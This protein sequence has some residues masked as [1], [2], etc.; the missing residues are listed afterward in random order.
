VG[1]RESLPINCENWWEAYAF[2]IWDEGFLPSAAE[3]EYAAAGGS[4]QREYPW[5]SADPGVANQYAIYLCD[6]P[7]IG[8]CTG[9]T[10]IAPVGTPTLGAGRWGQLDLA[11]NVEEWTL[12][13]AG[14]PSMCV[15]CFFVPTGPGP[16][17]PSRVSEGGGYGFAAW[18]LLN[19]GRYGEDPLLRSSY[20]GLRCARTP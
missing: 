6:Y 9:V 19:S 16:F 15:D 13:W 17:R 18:E 20:A 5:G 12:D 1:S 10:N 11:G 14:T 3:W 7:T 2:C 4:E 8:P